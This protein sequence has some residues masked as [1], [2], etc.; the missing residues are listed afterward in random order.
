MMEAKRE[1]RETLGNLETECG[2]AFKFSSGET[3]DDRGKL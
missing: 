2:T 3:P 1:S